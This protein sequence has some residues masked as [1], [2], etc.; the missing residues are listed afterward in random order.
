MGNGKPLKVKIPGAKHNGN[1]EVEIHVRDAWKSWGVKVSAIAGTILLFGLVVGIWAQVDTVLDTTD[2]VKRLEEKILCQ[3]VTT[4]TMK[5]IRHDTDAA[6]FRLLKAIT[7]AVLE[8]EEAET[9]IKDVEQ[10][11]E[12]DIKAREN[13]EK[14]R[15]E[16]IRLE[17][18]SAR[19]SKN[20]DG[21]K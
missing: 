16:R 13:A 18:E 9:L 20:R 11:L 6:Q 1:G 10:E 8:K 19:N 2:K 5:G 15:I 14:I 12:K 17:L 4:D 7:R 3:E 21:S